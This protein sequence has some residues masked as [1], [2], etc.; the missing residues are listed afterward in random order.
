MNGNGRGN[1]QGILIYQSKSTRG[2]D[3]LWSLGLRKETD[4]YDHKK[5]GYCDR[6]KGAM[7]GGRQGIGGMTSHHEKKPRFVRAR[8]G[9]ATRVDRVSRG[10]SFSDLPPARGK[11]GT[12]FS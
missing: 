1:R 6:R 11:K 9:E 3:D 12:S 4:D 8:D 7:M 5:A 2:W 10:E